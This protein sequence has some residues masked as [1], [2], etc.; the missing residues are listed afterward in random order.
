MNS[1]KYLINEDQGV[2]YI[3]ER[4]EVEATPKGKSIQKRKPLRKA[5]LTLGMLGIF[6]GASAVTI[7]QFASGV[8]QSGNTQTQDSAG[9]AKTNGSI[10]FAGG[11]ES[12]DD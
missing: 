3:Y 7:G 2:Q 5:L 12:G 1:N 10:S 11:N 8:G 4:A 6:A 9:A